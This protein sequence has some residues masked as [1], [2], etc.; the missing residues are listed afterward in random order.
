VAD[1]LIGEVWLASG[2]SN[3]MWF[4]KDAIGGET[5][6]AASANSQLRQ[7]LVSKKVGATPLEGVAGSWLVAGPKTSL[8]F[9]A[10]GYYAGK[11]LQ[12]ELK[13][14]V[15]L[16]NNSWG[17]SPIQSWISRDAYDASAPDLKRRAD[18]SRNNYEGFP[19][20][21][22]DY[23]ELLRSWEASHGRSLPL[24]D[25]VTPY[26]AA[27][28]QTTDWKPVTL[29]GAFAAAGLPDAGAIWF[30]RTVTLPPEIASAR[31]QMTLGGLTGFFTAYWNGAKLA[32]TK[33]ENGSSFK[34]D[35]P[36]YIP[37]AIPLKAGEGVLA[38]RLVVATEGA[39]IAGPLKW[40]SLPL[41]GDWQAKVEKALP[42]LDAAARAACPKAL[43]PPFQSVEVASY[44]Y[45]GVLAPVI[46]Y[47]IRG[48]LWYQGESNVWFAEQYRT[49]FPMM[50][51]DWR[52]QWKQ[53]DFPFYFCQLPNYHAPKPVPGNSD[54]ADL[55]E[56]QAMALSLP[57]TGMAVFL[58]LGE[59]GS[60]HPRD[61]RV[62]GE[63]LAAVVLANTYGKKIPFAGP[64]QTSVQ[65]EGDAV[66]VHFSNTDGGLVAAPLPAE[67]VPNSLE[68]GKKLP[69]TRN[70]PDSQI[71]GFALCGEDHVWKWAEAKIDGDTVVVRAE[72]VAKPVFIRYAWADYPICNLYNGAGFPA[73]PFR[74]D[75]FPSTTTGKGFQ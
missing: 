71:E 2:Q 41:N 11:R 37:G 72:G 12:N 57:N 65:I 59:A 68:P 66:R 28:A 44:V 38:I 10:V 39:A 22:K 60:V 33:A 54:L 19:A 69:L 42:P 73:L 46:P 36:F 27:T 61:K 18:R 6:I 31:P 29:P 52:A 70:T 15:G 14:P 17:G 1:V 62:A 58:D 13:V 5:E 26:T 3:M 30:R 51:K 48:A 21:K 24:P 75:K 56:A 35:H 25:D 74:T 53:G 40:G 49:L 16:I 4:L 20:R 23:E 50:I 7:F 64:T 47:A 34:G 43:M 9:S 63:R 55:R 8:Y 32:E 67:Y 45:N